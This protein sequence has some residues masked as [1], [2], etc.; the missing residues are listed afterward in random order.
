M[1]PA[2]FIKGEDPRSVNVPSLGVPDGQ[3][4]T[5]ITEANVLLKLPGGGG[6]E[7]AVIHRWRELALPI[8]GSTGRVVGQG[9]DEVFERRGQGKGS[10]PA[11]AS[12][13]PG[14]LGP[15][16]QVLAALGQRD[17][18][19]FVA[20]NHRLLQLNQSQVVVPVG[21]ILEVWMENHLEGT[22]VEGNLASLLLLVNKDPN[23]GF[24]VYLT[25]STTT[26][27]EALASLSSEIPR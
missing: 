18:G 20:D 25:F 24:A 22:E 2:G 9:D 17:G 1:L 11:P 21:L 23:V 10:P 6:A 3:S 26:S 16:C 13:Y 8:F 19:H 7:H 5:T 14:P 15:V 12:Y 27:L 4:T